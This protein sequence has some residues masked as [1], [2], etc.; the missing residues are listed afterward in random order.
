MF[1]CTPSKSPPRN[2]QRS[3]PKK[4]YLRKASDSYIKFSKDFSSNSFKKSF[5]DVSIH[6]SLFSQECW[7][8]S[9][10]LQKLH[11]IIFSAILHYFFEKF[12]RWFEEWWTSEGF[13]CKL[14]QG[15]HRDTSFV[16]LKNFSKDYFRNFINLFRK[17]M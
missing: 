8:I 9:E 5:G 12:L 6:S 15:F 2:L 17:S 14:F 11:C 3:F 16:S 10:F 1:T 4:N 13:V 7:I